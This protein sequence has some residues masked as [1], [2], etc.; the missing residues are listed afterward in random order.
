MNDEGQLFADEI[1]VGCNIASLRFAE[2][3]N[4]PV[5]YTGQDFPNFFEKTLLRI[6]QNSAST[7]LF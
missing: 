1:V 4:I 2:E 6:L 5:V 7:F 3:N